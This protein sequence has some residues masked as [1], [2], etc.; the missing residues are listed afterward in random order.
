[1]ASNIV[2]A[3]ERVLVI[4][5]G[6][7][8]D[9][10]CLLPALQILAR[11]YWDCDLELM[12]RAELADFAVGRMSIA[13]GHSIDRRELG[14]LFS[15]ADNAAEAAEFFGMFSCIHSFF[16]HDDPRL[17]QTLPQACRGKVFF[18]P[19]R[20]VAGGHVAAAY[21]ESIGDPPGDPVLQPAA[22]AIDLNA[23]D[24]AEACRLLELR[25]VE[26]GHFILLMPGSGSR[27]KNWPAESYLE[28]A[29]H[30]GE[31]TPIVTVLG[32]AEEDLD[33]VFSGLGPVKSPPLG[34]LAGMARLSL[35]FIGNDSGTSHLAA[36]AGGHGMVIFGPTDPERWRPLG[37]VT[38]LRRMPLQDLRWPE[39]AQA[40]KIQR[41]RAESNR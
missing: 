24:L 19:F 4:F 7:L 15:A 32:P 20:P 29:R 28:L 38:V 6:A 30:L 18:H 22:G 9:L 33:Q 12:A 17:R 21:V 35:A 40:L 2:S 39:V 25:G 41:D 14:L 1:M 31:S 5:P 26:P 11:R 13:R 8:G 3:R 36:A 34:T 10:M 37:R 16:G 27:T 23:A